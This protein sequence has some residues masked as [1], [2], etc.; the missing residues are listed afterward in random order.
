M[1]E[2][3]PTAQVKI[4]QAVAEIIEEYPA[5]AGWMLLTDQPIDV[6]IEGDDIQCLVLRSFGPEFDHSFEPGAQVLNVLTIDVEAIVRE[7]CNI[8]DRRAKEGLAHV[9][10]ALAA[11]RTLG[12]RLQDLMEQDVAP[13]DGQR[14]DIGAVSMQW[15]AEYLTAPNDPFTIYGHAGMAF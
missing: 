6:A 7:T 3:V 13:G 5:L 1:A 9:Q 4:E 15:R 12:N 2:P 10:A 11:D 8:K 14:R